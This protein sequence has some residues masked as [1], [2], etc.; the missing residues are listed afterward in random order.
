MSFLDA[1][2]SP[3]RCIQ[4]YAKVIADA[5][6][7]W[8]NLVVLFSLGVYVLETYLLSRQ[9]PYYS[10][11]APP[12]A[13]SQH[14]PGETF[15]KSQNYGRDK[16]RF[17][18]VYSAFGEILGIGLIYAGAQVWAWKIAGEWLTK[19]GYVG[20]E[21]LNPFHGIL[22]LASAIPFLPLS[23]YQTFV[24]EEK[25]GFNKMN[26]R[27]FITDTLKGWALTFFI[28]SP[29]LAGFLWIIR[30][31][32]DGFI[33]WLMSFLIA[34][35]LVMVVLYPTVIQPLFN[36]LSPLP[37]GPLRT[38]IEALASRLKFPL[39][40]LYVIDGS[41]RSAHSNAYFYGLPW[42]KHIVI[43]DT[44]I[45]QSAPEEIEAVLAHELGHWW[46]SH[47]LKLMIISEVHLLLLFSA[48]PAF[49][50]SA[51]LLTSFGFP[52][53]VA[54][55]PPIIISFMLFQNLFTPVEALLTMAMNAVSRYFEWQADKFA[56]E[57]DVSDNDEKAATE[58]KDGST[59]G[60]A[61]DDM[62]ERLAKALIGL[63]KENLSSVWVDWLYSAYH[64][65]HPT[66]PERL[67]VMDDLRS[68]KNLREGAS[69]KKEL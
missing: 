33:P 25:H 4:D 3:L 39:T 37:Q 58:G 21:V 13:L 54:R 56:F 44:L 55:H 60:V 65:S 9:Y 51:S 59:D 35:Q 18:F 17:A 31:A 36:K 29:F 19:W 69:A 14:F 40:D 57:Q 1:I 10:R 45:K 63:H 50:Q 2:L 41:K 28:G 20:Y 67:R 61:A 43:Y 32:G 62:G 16:A 22:L 7:D 46:Y 30:W 52:T 34:F 53:S 26:V 47:P 5:D 27:L 11:E 38:R 66:L 24:L 68:Q 23:Y 6:V 15:Q 49:L 48:F 8:K 42:S 12:P 64:H